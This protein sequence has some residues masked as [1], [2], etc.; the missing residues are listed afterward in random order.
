MPAA[1]LACRVALYGA[2]REEGSGTPMQVG[3]LS[4]RRC[5]MCSMDCEAEVLV[6][7]GPNCADCSDTPVWCV[8]RGNVPVRKCVRVWNEVGRTCLFHLPLSTG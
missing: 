7:A 2:R 8:G 6:A 5:V 3:Y 1:L 4:C